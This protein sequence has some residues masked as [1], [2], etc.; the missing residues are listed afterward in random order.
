MK[1]TP[2]KDFFVVL[3]STRSNASPRQGT[4]DNKSGAQ[5][6]S[7]CIL[8]W[9]LAK[10][11]VHSP[12]ARSV[13]KLIASSKCLQTKL[14][15]LHLS[16][17]YRLVKVETVLHIKAVS[18]EK[19]EYLKNYPL[20]SEQLCNAEHSAS[21]KKSIAVELLGHSSCFLAQLTGMDTLQFSRQYSQGLS[22]WLRSS[23]SEYQHPKEI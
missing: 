18:K 14:I 7:S 23:K 8:F 21:G 3:V 9:D 12:S 5:A 17:P 15:C 13:P 4:S 2:Q 1:N 22:A 19:P 20:S 6:P 11:V 10:D 16:Q